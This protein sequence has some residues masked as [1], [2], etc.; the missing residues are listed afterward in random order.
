MAWTPPLPNG[1]AMCP[2]GGEVNHLNEEEE[3]AMK[4]TTIGL[5]LAKHVFQLHGVDQRGK[6]V[7]RKQIKRAQVL[8]YFANL[9]PRQGLVKKRTAAANRWRGRLGA[10]GVCGKLRVA[11]RVGSP[12]QG[13]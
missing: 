8:P 5:D 12:D 2:S 4:A 11:G 6:T 13:I 7:L 3:S 1:I 9:P 10:V